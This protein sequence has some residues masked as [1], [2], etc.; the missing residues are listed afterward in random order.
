ML[1]CSVLYYTLHEL[2][3]ENHDKQL[4]SHFSVINKLNDHNIVSVIK[5]IHVL[6]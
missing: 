2:L 6:S 3:N 4:S 1:S 5:L